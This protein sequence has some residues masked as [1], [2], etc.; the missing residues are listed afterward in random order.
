MLHQMNKIGQETTSVQSVIFGEANWLK[1][2]AGK[3]I[4]KF[5][6]TH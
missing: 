5:A 3:I 2:W 4:S 1:I 6:F